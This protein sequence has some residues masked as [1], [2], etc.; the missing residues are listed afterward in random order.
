MKYKLRNIYS[1]EPELAL[2][3]ILIDRGVENIG[4]F[5]H[6]SKEACELNPYDLENIKTGADMLL[7]HLRENH[8][9]LF[10]VD[11]D[12]DGF[13]SS[14]IL[15][16]YCKHLFPNANFEFRVHEHKEHGLSDTIDWV[17]EK[18]RWDLVICP[19]S[20][21]YD[22]QEHLRLGELGIDCLILDHHD[23]LY[24]EDGNPVVTTAPNTVVINNQ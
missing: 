24:D 5:L 12:V 11:C 15:W 7:R 18:V 13:S 3:D 6:P 8:H 20:S 17:E 9:I 4:T 10:L 21:S 22:V 23:Q 2:Q 1:I 14:A 19:D 16:L